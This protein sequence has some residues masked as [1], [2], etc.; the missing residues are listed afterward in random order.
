MC[1]G[2]GFRVLLGADGGVRVWD[3]GTS[4]V[5]CHYPAPT[6]P[7]EAGIEDCSVG[8]V[9]WLSFS[10]DG[11]LLATS[12]RS[13]IKVYDTRKFNPSPAPGDG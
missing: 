8:G 1:S 11:A 4:E 10:Q 2:L 9:S 12:L 3:L 13:C 7:D 5:L 6:I